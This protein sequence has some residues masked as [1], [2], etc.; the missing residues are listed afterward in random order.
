[1]YTGI[2]YLRPRYQQY[3]QDQAK[4]KASLAR[5]DTT[6]GGGGGGGNHTDT[7]TVGN[8]SI[9]PTREASTLSIPTVR[10]TIF[11]TIRDTLRDG[12][13]D[14]ETLLALAEEEEA[15]AE[16]DEATSLYVNNEE[17]G[18]QLKVYVK[19]DDASN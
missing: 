15:E 4:L 14:E 13:I 9:K 1:M 18:D 2:V 3:R 17:V 6:G 19:V 7:L 12:G 5:S 11:G 8:S 10:R 16:T